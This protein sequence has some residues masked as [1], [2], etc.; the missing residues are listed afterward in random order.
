[1]A[2]PVDAGAGRHSRDTKLHAVVISLGSRHSDHNLTA[3][4]FAIRK[5][6]QDL[7]NVTLHNIR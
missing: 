2:I 7:K 1:M 6:G 5:E 4:G 3:S